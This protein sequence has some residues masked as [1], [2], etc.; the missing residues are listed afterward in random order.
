MNLIT[1]NNLMEHFPTREHIE[2]ERNILPSNVVIEKFSWDK[3]KIFTQISNSS[4]FYFSDPDLVLSSN[5]L[6]GTDSISNVIIQKKY[7]FDEIVSS[8]LFD[9]N[10]YYDNNTANY[11]LKDGLAH[12]LRTLSEKNLSLEKSTMEGILFDHLHKVMKSSN[13]SE[14]IGLVDGILGEVYALILSVDENSSSCEILKDTLEFVID[15][16]IDMKTFPWNM[17][18]FPGS[19]N[20]SPYLSNGSAGLLKTLITWSKKFNRN[21]FDTVITNISNALSSITFPQCCTV[22]SGI[23]GIVDSLLDT[24]AY[25]GNTTYLNS[26]ERMLF[27]IQFFV[28]SKDSK[29]YIP[30]KY[31]TTTGLDYAG[32]VS[33]IYAV[34]QRYLYIKEDV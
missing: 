26:I 14:P 25:N 13:F 24:V 28:I 15:N 4:D 1:L 6:Y 16:Y 7:N 11:S 18:L 31:F 19:K 10:Q 34:Y 21:D 5:H 32:G 33:G 20:V 17:H 3:Y 9:K 12:T 30:S 23:A 2:I 8:G 27:E 22:D 29:L